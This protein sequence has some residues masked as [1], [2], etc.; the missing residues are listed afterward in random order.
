MNET[1]PGHLL[2]RGS[3]IESEKATA[4]LIQVQSGVKKENLQD[5]YR[6]TS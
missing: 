6:H 5:L 1:Q 2:S 3:L 4:G